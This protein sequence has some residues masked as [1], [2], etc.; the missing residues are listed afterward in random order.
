MALMSGMFKKPKVT[1]PEP[2]PPLP[3]IDQAQADVER[4]NKLGRRKGRRANQRGGA[5]AAPS[6]AV[7]TLLGG[8]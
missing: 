4:R 6:V 1:V 8:P 3:T 7:R 2:P 5:S